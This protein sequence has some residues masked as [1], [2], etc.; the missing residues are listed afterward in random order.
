MA[1]YIAI[2]IREQEVINLRRNGRD[3]GGVRG[4][5]EMGKL[6]KYLYMKI[7]KIKIISCFGVNTQFILLPSY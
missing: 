3:M 4:R 1:I 2:I 5:K 6:Y 7:S